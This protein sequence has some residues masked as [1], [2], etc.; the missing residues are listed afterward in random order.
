MA[1]VTM[2]KVS[3]DPDE[4]L[5]ITREELGPVVDETAPANGRISSTIAR[6]DTGLM[7]INVWEDEEGMRRTAE[8]V[9]PIARERG[10]PEQEDWQMYEVLD[11]A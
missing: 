6:T 2:F 1:I 3:G 9:G 8:R 7:I 11:R 5:R 4:L 10:M